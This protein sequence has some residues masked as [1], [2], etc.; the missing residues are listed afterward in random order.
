MAT[1]GVVA[2]LSVVGFAQ[3]KKTMPSSVFDWDKIEAKTT[4]TGASRDFFKQP[5]TNL[6]QLECHVTTLNPGEAP[7]A[8]HQHFEEEL[9]IV[10][11]GVIEAMQ[12]GVIKR[13]GAG[14]IIFEAS[15]DRHGLRNVGQ[16]PAT[17]YVIKWFPPGTL[18]TKN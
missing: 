15:N 2:T 16:T 5:T 3:S 1:L 14:S 17:Y 7:H 4:P 6:D 9:I 8:P 18:K 13:A 11:D 12:N 10:K